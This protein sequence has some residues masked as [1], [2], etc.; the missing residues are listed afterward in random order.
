MQMPLVLC[1][2][3][4]ASIAY[5]TQVPIY[6]QVGTVLLKEQ[7]HDW[8]QCRRARI[9]VALTIPDGS[10]AL[11]LRLLEV[12]QLERCASMWVVICA[13]P[14]FRSPR[15]QQRTATGSMSFI[16]HHYQLLL[17]VIVPRIK[18]IL[19]FTLTLSDP[20]L[21]FSLNAW[22]FLMNQSIN[23]SRLLPY[24]RKSSEW[25]ENKTFM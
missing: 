18:F 4:H 15:C 21:S 16:W 7:V 14:R 8:W 19:I 9:L 1:L 12:Q 20:F 22:L 5:Q 3:Q 11:Y 2:I 6:R 10:M 25:N 13:T 23:K 17:L 24:N